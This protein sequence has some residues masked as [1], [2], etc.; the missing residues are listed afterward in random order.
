M[1]RQR[2]VLIFLSIFITI[3]M[4]GCANYRE[5][6]TLAVV[7]GT[8]F[9]KGSDGAGYHLTFEILG[10]SAGGGAQGPAVK[11][12]L[13]ESDGNTIFDAVRNALKKSDKK[14]YYGDCKTVIIS[15]ELAREGIAPVLDWLNRDSEPRITI[16][17][18][19]SKEKTAKE[20]IEQKSLNNPITS[21]ALSNIDKNN[22]KFLSKTAY[23]QLYQ[24]NNMLG[25]EGISL[26]LPA[27]DIAN[28]QND[29]I[30]E[31]GGT[32]VFKKDKLLG[33][34]GSDESKYLVFTKNQVTSGLLIINM[35]SASPGIS[36]EIIESKTKVIPILTGKLPE[37][38]IEIKMQVALGEMQTSAN[39]NTESGIKKIEEK[40]SATIEANIKQLITK[41][42]REYDSDIFGFGSAIYKNNPDYWKEMKPQW[43]SLFQSLNIDVSAEVEIIN[44]GLSKS[45][46][47]VGG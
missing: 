38:K 15:N 44:T 30:T 36:L 26:I 22:P 37:M 1:K 33:Y 6:E 5:L 35:E 8:A 32:A 42:Q 4:T 7:T 43:D 11:S 46:V 27:L 16:D 24:A 29:K 39:L 9:D 20:V 23:V 21:Y 3:L 14:L 17:L 10:Q 19:I 47:K 28:N 45:K 31:L 41:V 18:F 2:K 40:A 12:Q 34:L 25:G 13:I